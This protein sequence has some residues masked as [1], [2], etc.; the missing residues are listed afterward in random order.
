MYFLE[1]LAVGAWGFW[2]LLAISALV[3]S[4]AVDSSKYGL[5]TLT[6]IGVIAVLALFSNVNIVAW[7]NEHPYD[8]LK[9]VVGYLSIGVAW[10]FLK[11]ILWLKKIRRIVM[12]YKEE[13]P[14]VSLSRIQSML[15]NR[16]YG[17]DIPPKV[18]NYKAK[19]IGWM[20]FWPGSFVWTLINDP[21]RRIFETIYYKIARYMQRISDNLFED[22]AKPRD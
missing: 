10:A 14:T 11:W 22:I 1:F 4:E 19:I 13:D 9:Y 5:A 6:V 8:T 17:S 16:G 7:I 20:S 2:L 3:I 21:V 12:A 18:G 15:Y